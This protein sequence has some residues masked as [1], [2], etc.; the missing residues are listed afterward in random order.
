VGQHQREF[1]MMEDPE[2]IGTKIDDRV[3]KIYKRIGFDS[4]SK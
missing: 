3:K 2:L 1:G 4:H